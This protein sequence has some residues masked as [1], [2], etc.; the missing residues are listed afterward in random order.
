MHRRGFIGSVAASV[1][2]LMGIKLAKANPPAIVRAGRWDHFM[3]RIMKDDGVTR[4][5]WFKN[6]APCRDDEVDVSIDMHR[7]E[8]G[9]AH[10]AFTQK[11]N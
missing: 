6:G 9:V 8:E 2:W 10:W 7:D 5:Q 3:C 11:S 1:A 4:V